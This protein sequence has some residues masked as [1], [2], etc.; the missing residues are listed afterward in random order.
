MMP[1]HRFVSRNWVPDLSAGH[2]RSQWGKLFFCR[3]CNRSVPTPWSHHFVWPCHIII[4]SKHKMDPM[5]P[6]PATV[7]LYLHWEGICA[8][9]T[10]S[11]GVWLWMTLKMI[12][13][14][15]VK[16]KHIKE[17]AGNTIFHLVVNWV[18]RQL[19]LLALVESPII[20]QWS[21]SNRKNT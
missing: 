14:P 3:W 16:L 17:T 13:Q 4:I 19:Q 10:T 12:D 15:L 8:S 18:Q 9:I 5:F 7:W 21:E 11:S 20:H 6:K 2:Q 1:L